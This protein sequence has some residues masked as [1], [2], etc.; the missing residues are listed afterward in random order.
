MGSIM[1]AAISSVNSGVN[2]EFRLPD[3]ATG[4]NEYSVCSRRYN[5]K[6]LINSI[7]NGFISI[8]DKV[9]C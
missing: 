5:A 9:M 8:L 7:E 3:R 4:R 1:V 6:I 2:S